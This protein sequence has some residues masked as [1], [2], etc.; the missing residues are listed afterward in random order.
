VAQDF[1]Y[2]SRLSLNIPLGSAWYSCRLA[3]EPLVIIA[4]S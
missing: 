4:R 2:P 3:R 1:G